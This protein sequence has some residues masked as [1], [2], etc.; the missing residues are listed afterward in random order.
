MCEAHAAVISRKGPRGSGKG[1]RSKATKSAGIKT[2]FWFR[3]AHQGKS[4]DGLSGW[5]LD[6]A[7]IIYSEKLYLYVN[8][9]TVLDDQETYIEELESK[10][11]ELQRELSKKEQKMILS[12]EENKRIAQE[13]RKEEVIAII[14]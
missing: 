7:F 13:V 2:I 4:S 12:R 9:A 6:R 14:R 1:C 10:I 11:T 3:S 8:T 5:S